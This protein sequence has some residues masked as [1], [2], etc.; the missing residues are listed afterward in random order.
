PLKNRRSCVAWR[1]PPDGG[2][3]R[4]PLFLPLTPIRRIPPLEVL[5][6]REPRVAEDVERAGGAGT[7]SAVEDDLRVARQLVQ[8]IGQLAE[9]DVAGAVDVAGAPFV[10]LAHVDGD[11]A[12]RGGGHLVGVGGVAE[13][14]VVD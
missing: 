6:A 13:R 11:R 9:G 12:G 8:A 10:G 4:S 7:G 14:V 5:R 1:S 2:V 3:L